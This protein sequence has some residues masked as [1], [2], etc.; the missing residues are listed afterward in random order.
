MLLHLLSGSRTPHTRRS[1]PRFRLAVEPLEGRALLTRLPVNLPAA[2]TSRGAAVGGTLYLSAADGAHGDE[3][4]KASGTSATSVAPSD[5][6]FGSARN[7]PLPA[8]ASPEA[9][10]G[11]VS[12]ST[13]P[14]VAVLTTDRTPDCEIESPPP[15][16]V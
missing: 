9:R 6:R 13:T 2:V 16:I 11:I 12:V 4:W 7:E 8:I 1:R 3:L 15:P 14:L 10:F 5:I